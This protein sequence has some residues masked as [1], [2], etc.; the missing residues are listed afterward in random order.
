MA[1]KR[2]MSHL[3]R[4]MV[5]YEQSLFPLHLVHGHTCGVEKQEEPRMGHQRLRV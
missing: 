1:H 3:P 2:S 4:K 5:E